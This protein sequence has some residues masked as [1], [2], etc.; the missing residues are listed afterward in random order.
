MVGITVACALALLEFKVTRC[1]GICC[2]ELATGIS[3]AKNF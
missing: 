1:H 3:E 2:N